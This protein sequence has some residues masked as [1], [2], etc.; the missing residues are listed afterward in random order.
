MQTTTT[1]APAAVT[2]SHDKVGADDTATRRDLFACTGD[3]F[4]DHGNSGM[5]APMNLPSGSVLAFDT[6]PGPCFA[7]PSIFFRDWLL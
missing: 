1:A 4:L 5:D 2:T 3:A 7:A 6:G